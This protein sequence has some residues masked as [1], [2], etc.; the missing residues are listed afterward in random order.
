[1]FDNSKTHDTSK[2]ALT[3]RTTMALDP[4]AASAA[5]AVPVDNNDI[6]KEISDSEETVKGEMKANETMNG[7]EN[8]S[9][10]AAARAH[11]GIPYRDHYSLAYPSSTVR[12]RS[13]ATSHRVYQGNRSQF[14]LQERN[15]ELT[16]KRTRDTTAGVMFLRAVY[17]VVAVLWSGFLFVFCTQLLIFLVMNLA[18][19]L[20]GTT[21]S[22]VAVGRA[23]GTIL[24]FPV[25]VHG[26]AS[27]LIIDGNFVADTWAGQY[28]IK[29]LVFGGIQAVLPAWITFGF[30]LGFPLF[31]MGICL[32]SGVA[33]WWS[34]TAIFWFSCVSVFYVLFAVVVIYFEIHACLEIVGNE[35]DCKSDK[36]TLLKKCVLLRQDK[37][38]SGRKSRVYLARGSLHDVDSIRDPISE[39]PIQYHESL[40]S[41]FTE[42]SFLQK[43]GMFQRLQEPGQRIYPVEESQGVRPFVTYT[44]WR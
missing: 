5:E 21:G 36:R 40:Y 17:T 32:L 1:M 7:K 31:V 16:V 11:S 44:T 9:S 20:G 23:I 43:I 13:S 2:K 38:Y 19:Y 24:S 3:T 14:V 42:W 8:D 35:Y 25:F 30:F 15:Q 26:L 37:T 28:L 18:V 22:E 39:E 34:I 41:R 29:T 10:T 6:E 27:A 12:F 4:I 33:N